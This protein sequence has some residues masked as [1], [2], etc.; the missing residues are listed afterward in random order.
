MSKFYDFEA[1]SLRGQKVPMSAYKGKVVL[2]VNTASKCSFT[3]QYK[4]LEELY[5]K[6]KDRGLEVLG[7]PCNQFGKQ[8]PGGS[9]DIQ[10]FCQVNYGVS[11]PMFE[12]IDV[13]GTNTHP[14][15]SYLK[16][17]KGGFLGSNIKWNF[18]K[19]LIDKNGKVVKRFGPIVKPESIES[20]IQSLLKD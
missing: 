18:T 7:F 12:K 14:L 2:V 16:S 19:F 9:S 5:E 6:Y 20:K 1:N 15:Y 10:E 4:G 8:E 11:F 17:E 13:N 3:P